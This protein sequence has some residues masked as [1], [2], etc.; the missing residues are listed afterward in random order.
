MAQPPFAPGPWAPPPEVARPVLPGTMVIA[1]MGRRLGAYILDGLILAIAGIAVLAILT[2]IGGWA[3]RIPAN[4]D[5]LATQYNMPVIVADTVC[6]IAVSLAYWIY[7]WTTMRASPGMKAL[8][9]QIG[10]AES[11]NNL[12]VEQAVRRWIAIGSP[13]ALISLLQP[14]VALYY[15]ASSVALGWVIVLL[16]T[17]LNHPLR[18]GLHDRLADSLI[19]WAP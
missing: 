18:R 14:I 9:L 13:I 8:G 2:S 6:G 4:G 16:V 3:Y 15:V 10:Q 7:S 11:G 1:P 19:V 12:T 5:P 17:T